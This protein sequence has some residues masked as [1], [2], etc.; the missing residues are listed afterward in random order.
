VQSGDGGGTV[1]FAYLDLGIG[2]TIVEVMELNV[3]TRGMNDQIRDA[4][5]QW[6]GTDP[7][8]SLF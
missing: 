7:V 5:D 6:D 2:G 4:A 1:R 3:G 8:R